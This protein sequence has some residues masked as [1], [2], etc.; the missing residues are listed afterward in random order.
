VVLMMRS[1]EPELDDKIDMPVSRNVT[2]DALLQMIRQLPVPAAAMQPPGPLPEADPAGVSQLMD[3]G[4]SEER[5]KKALLLNGNNIEAAAEWIFQHMDDPDID[6][7]LTP[8]QLHQLAGGGGGLLG[9]L[10]MRGMM[11]GGGAP[12][13]QA[14]SPPA[15]QPAPVTPEVQ[16]LLQQFEPLMRQVA[17]IARGNNAQRSSV[18][19]Q[20][21]VLQQ[22][23]WQLN[24]AIR[25]LWA[26]ERNLA[27]LQRGVDTNS[28]NLISRMLELINNGS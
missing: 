5:A 20:L 22:R 25:A 12:A 28:A 23:G 15:Q 19:Q 16:A 2:A 6:V 11:G 7:P 14:A 26:G 18:E 3:M 4:F 24:D 17:E 9:M 13:A 8:M 21:P 27:T 1:T 10:G